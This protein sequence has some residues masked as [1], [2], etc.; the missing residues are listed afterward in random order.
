MHNKDTY[1]KV[2]VDCEPLIMVVACFDIESEISAEVYFLEDRLFLHFD[3]LQQ[4]I[5]FHNATSEV[6]KRP[7]RLDECSI[8]KVPNQNQNECLVPPS[9]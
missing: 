4:F 6:T 8:I 3:V 1:I 5:C 2:C 9:Q 7:R